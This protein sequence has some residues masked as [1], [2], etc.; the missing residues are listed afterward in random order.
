M[1]PSPI[2]LPYQLRKTNLPLLLHLLYHLEKFA[3]VS[4]RACNDIC[5]TTQEVMI[6]FYASNECIE[7][8]TSIA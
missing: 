4:L 1:N 8:L 3:V 7:F 5:S 2:A 6:V